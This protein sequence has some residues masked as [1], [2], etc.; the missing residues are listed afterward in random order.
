MKKEVFSFFLF[1]LFACAYTTRAQAVNISDASQLVSFANQYADGIGTDVVSV[2]L[3]ADIDLGGVEW[4]PIGTVGKPFKGS[5]DGKG[6]VIKG[7]QTFDG[8]DGVGLFGH[9]AK[10]LLIP[11]STCSRPDISASVS[12]RYA[13]SGGMNFCGS[14]IS[15]A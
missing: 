5:F 7:L 9:I 12:K 11:S 10:K 13:Q 4:K 3:E 2:S 15:R 6:H 14:V 1:L 8:T